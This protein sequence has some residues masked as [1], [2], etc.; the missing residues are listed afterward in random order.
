M[1]YRWLCELFP[2][3]RVIHSTEEN[4]EAARG[5]PGALAIWAD[6]IRS[7][8]DGGITMLFASEHYGWELSR[9]IGARY[10]PVDPIRHLVPISASELRANPWR[11]WHHLPRIIRPYFARRVVVAAEPAG[12]SVDQGD[13]QAAGTAGKQKNGRLYGSELAY[14]LA[15]SFQTPLT[16]D[17]L[18]FWQHIEPQL[19]AELAH[20]PAELLRAQLASEEA[21]ARHANRVLFCCGDPIRLGAWWDLHFG[22]IPAVIEERIAVCRYDLYIAEIGSELGQRCAELARAHGHHLLS[23]DSAG[24]PEAAFRVVHEAVESLLR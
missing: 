21:L 8:V 5:E 2:D 19:T 1:R 18:A 24:D 11:H 22:T 13:R 9:L 23:I 12:P 7:R 20:D 6:T 17:Y 15:R 4:P 3:V 14:R 10:I 16:I